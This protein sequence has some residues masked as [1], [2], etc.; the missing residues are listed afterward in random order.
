MNISIRNLALCSGGTDGS[1]QRSGADS[2]QD[3]P[4]H[5][6]SLPGVRVQ[7]EVAPLGGGPGLVRI[8]MSHFNKTLN[9][10]VTINL[11]PSRT[12]FST[13]QYLLMSSSQLSNYH[14]LTGHIGFKRNLSH[15]DVKEYSYG[16]VVLVSND[17]DPCVTILYL[18]S[19]VSIFP[20]VVRWLLQNRE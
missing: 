8:T 19:T 20:V 3:L 11:P 7:Q 6:G 14:P 18:Q 17:K 16:D 1:L 4:R 9:W 5:W 2:D 15:D 13:D 12:V 10:T